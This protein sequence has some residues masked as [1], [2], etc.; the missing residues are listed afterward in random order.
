METSGAWQNICPLRRCA[1]QDI[2]ETGRLSERIS[3]GYHG[4]DGDAEKAGQSHYGAVR[5]GKT[6]KL[7]KERISFPH[8]P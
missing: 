1:G 5:E 8:V 4:D 2:Q 3:S 6:G 7:G